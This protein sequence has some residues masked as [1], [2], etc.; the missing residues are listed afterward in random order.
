MYEL[1]RFTIW[2]WSSGWKAL[3]ALLDKG[4]TVPSHNCIE[5]AALLLASKCCAAEKPWHIWFSH[6]MKSYMSIFPFYMF[7]STFSESSRHNIIRW[8]CKGAFG[9][10]IHFCVHCVMGEQRF[11]MI[12]CIL[13]TVHWDRV[14][15]P[16]ICSW[17]WKVNKW[18]Y[19]SHS[20]FNLSCVCHNVM[21]Y[22]GI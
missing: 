2:H 19:C 10:S 16:M 20:Y 13:S 15:T 4:C 1:N 12:A 21:R 7:S 6:A 14:L 8:T 5:L 11:M 18:I 9:F 22:E 3:N 17:L